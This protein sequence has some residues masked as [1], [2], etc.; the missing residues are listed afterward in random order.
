M[1]EDSVELKEFLKELYPN[2][3]ITDVA[4][5]SGQRVVYYGYFDK[6]S[7]S[8]DLDNAHIWGRIVLK[9]SEATSR[10]AI[11]YIQKEVEILREIDHP[12]YPKLHYSE[13]ITLD[14]F[15]EEP[16]SPIRFISVEERIDGIPI[17]N[18]MQLYKDEKIVTDF[19]IQT[20]RIM[21]TIWGHSQKLVHRDL[22][23]DNI[24][25]TELGQ[26]FIIDLGILREEGSSGVTNSLFPFGPCT[27]TYASPEQ[28]TN[29]KANI[30][31]KSDLFSLGVIAYEMLSGKNPFVIIG[32]DNYIDDILERV[33]SYTPSSLTSLGVSAGLDKIISKMMNKEPYKR[34]R[35]P[36]KLLNELNELNELKDRTWQ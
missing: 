30:T 18:K 19:L 15:T 32:E 27:P 3:V 35:T 6:A 16:L 1:L 22:K 36:N 31:F 33:C 17:S 20:I 24:L 25:V 7:N 9:I 8:V 14:P 26:I 11:T 13:V 21:N 23:P 4:K 5:K 34:Y 29:D 10:S 12:S 28:A 2:L